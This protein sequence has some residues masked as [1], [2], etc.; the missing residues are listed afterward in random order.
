MARSRPKIIA[1]TETFNEEDFLPTW[2]AAM[3][4][5]ADEIVAIDDGSE[6]RSADILEAHPK[7]VQVVRKRRAK[8]TEVKDLNRLVS[9]ARERGA[10]WLMRVD[11]DEVFDRR[12]LDRVDDLVDDADV[13]EYHF[14]KLWLWRSTD[15]VRVDRPDKFAQWNPHRLVRMRPDLRYVFPI[16]ATWKRLA[17]TALRHTRWTPQFGNGGVRP[18]GRAAQVDDVVLLHLAAVDWPDM[19]RKH[20]LYAVGKRDEYPR[21]PVDEIVR[22]AYDTLD[23][24]TLRIEA[25]APEWGLDVIAVRARELAAGR[26]DLA[27]RA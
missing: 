19:I 25:V 3:E 4:D 17:T 12:M 10:E 26:A 21:T 1:A 20:L 22:W 23:E 27:S 15:E 5:L 11:A 9:M 14:R 8:R 13:D 24:S 7:V 6:D 2:L 16:G 18:A